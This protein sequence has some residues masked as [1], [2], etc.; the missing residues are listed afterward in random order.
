MRPIYQ[1]S[2]C[3]GSVQEN[4]IECPHCHTIL[5]WYPLTGFANPQAT[6]DEDGTCLNPEPY[7]PLNVRFNPEDINQVIW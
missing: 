3:D 6:F 4:L 2:I 7:D 1:C 5:N